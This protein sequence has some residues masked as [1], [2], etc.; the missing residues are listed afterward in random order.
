MDIPPYFKQE[1]QATCTLAVLR[2]VLSYFSISVSEAQLE[3][4]VINDYGKKFSNIWT[5]L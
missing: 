5:R 4:Q 3:E 1:K 2:M